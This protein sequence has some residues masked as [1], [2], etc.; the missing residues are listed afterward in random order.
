MNPQ[1]GEPTVLRLAVVGAGA[2]SAIARHAVESGDARIVAAV[3]PSANARARAS[4]SFACE[5]TFE[6][7]DELIAAAAS[8][9]DIDAAFVTSPDDTH[10]EIAVALLNAGIAVYLEK[11]LAIDVDDAD[12]ILAASADSGTRLYVGHNMRHM[13]VVRT[14]RELILRGEIGEVKAIWCRHFVGNGGD[15][16]FKDWHADRSKAN[17]L[18]LQKGAHDIDVIHWLAGGT[19]EL[20]TGLGG[21]TLYGGIDDRRDNSDR[22]MPE[23]FSLDSWPPLSQTELNPVIDVEDLS[24]VAMRLD[25][26]VLASYQQCHYTPDYWRNYTVIGTE[27]RLENFGDGDGAIVRVWNTRTL[28]SEHGDAEYPVS[29][30]AGG[31]GDA[32]RLTVAEFV[33]FVRD[34]I[35]TTTSAVAA[36]DAVATAV[37]ATE[38]I[39]SEGAPRRVRPVDPGVAARL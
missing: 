18:L 38:S 34:G 19:S 14:M 12:A 5:A 17:G 30:D 24:M 37:A 20:V 21:L 1:H 9:L 23:W 13:S 11:P 2:R 35:A 25:N 33:A 27:G 29:G 3:D 7:L 32:D 26:G 10:A 22:T 36:R 6:T 28:Y 8:G 4:A 31:H 39:R 15:Y 16:Y